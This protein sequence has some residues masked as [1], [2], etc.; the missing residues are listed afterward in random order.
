MDNE[1]VSVFLEGVR[2]NYKL[3]QSKEKAKVKPPTSWRTDI[4]LYKQDLNQAVAEIKQDRD[5]IMKMERFYPSVDI[6]ASIDKCVYEYWSQEAGWQNKR[7]KRGETDW[8]KTFT[9]ALSMHFNRVYKSKQAVTT[10][11]GF[12]V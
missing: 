7:R 2:Y 1:L 4:N 10:S 9:N 6:I 12:V 11:R 5:W 3:N 8:K